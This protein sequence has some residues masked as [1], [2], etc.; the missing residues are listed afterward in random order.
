MLILFFY[1]KVGSSGLGLVALVDRI[2]M[3]KNKRLSLMLNLD[4]PV[5]KTMVQERYFRDLMHK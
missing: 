5:V 2:H 4:D 1:M 3:M